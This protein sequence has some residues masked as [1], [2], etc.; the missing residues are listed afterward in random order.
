M[1]NRILME[2]YD[3]YEK[4]DISPL[5]EFAT[6]TFPQDGTEKLFIGCTLILFKEAGTYKPRY[7]ASRE[8]LYSI[9]SS[10]REKIGPSNLLEYYIER[11]N[12]KK[13]INKYLKDVIKDKNIDKYASTLLDYLDQFKPTFLSNLK[14]DSKKIDEF[15]KSKNDQYKKNDIGEV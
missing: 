6:K 9:I 11:V 1:I 3:D 12:T 8:N 15:I 7:Y 5:I 14:N 13:G 10:A 2:L 4:K